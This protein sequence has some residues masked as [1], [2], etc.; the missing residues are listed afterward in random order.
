MREILEH[1]YLLPQVVA[2]LVA[3][4]WILR[5]VGAVRGLPTVPNLIEPEHD[6]SPEG[7]PFITVIVPARNEGPNV[8]A[9]LESLLAQDYEQLRIIAVDDRSDDDTGAIMDSL[10]C[11]R[12][13]VLHIAELPAQWLGKPHAMALAADHAIAHHS[14]DFLL[15]TDADVMFRRDAIRRALANAVATGADHF[16]VGPTTII[17]RWDEAA[18]LS[19]F[20]I[21]GM[22]A[23]RPWKVSDP[24]ALRDAIGI[25]AF[26]LVRTSAYLRVGGF[27]ALR[28]EVVEDL[29]L[30]RR[31]KLA[32]LAQRFV[33]GRGL[34]SVHWA[35]GVNGIV[36]VMTKN[37][38][39]IF[40]FR[41]GFLLFGCAW[42]TLFC[43]MPFIAVWS[44]PFTLPA[45][46]V[47]IAMFV[48]YFIVS[49]HSGLSGWNALFAPFAASL[50]IYTLLRSMTTTLV[51]GGVI[52][53]GTFYSLAELREHSTPIIPRR[54]TTRS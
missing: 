54:P 16:V 32:G 15:F 41:I 12:L 29:G 26:N 6:L 48:L 38:F 5:V 10:A 19:F 3:L 22:W 7:A 46:C 42:L 17:R 25:G 11:S 45:A 1:V 43:V 30:A 36:N 31:V 14:P 47:I 13:E 34:V 28:M 4:A 39:S 20:Q 37:I 35:S 24:K 44:A 51:Q 52:W 9:C 2:W 21:L 18:L 50:F 27:E 33:F 49:R 53:R 8:R 23:A 40:R